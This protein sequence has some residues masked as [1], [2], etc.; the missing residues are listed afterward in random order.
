MPLPACKL[1]TVS[2]LLSIGGAFQFG[3]QLLITNPAQPAFEHFT[4][5][6]KDAG[7]LDKNTVKVG[8][9]KFKILLKVIFG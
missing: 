8:I 5:T 2:I 3:Y 9:V 6:S 1:F 4:N 7:P